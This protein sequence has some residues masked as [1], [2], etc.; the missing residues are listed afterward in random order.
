MDVRPD[1]RSVAR[2]GA[3]TVATAARDSACAHGRE[4]LEDEPIVLLGAT[5]EQA[6]DG[7]RRVDL[8]GAEWH[9]HQCIA[10]PTE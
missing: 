4:V 1:W 3:H 5:T 9:P 8:S 2:R 7:A 6:P 10:T